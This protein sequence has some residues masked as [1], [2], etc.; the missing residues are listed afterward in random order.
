MSDKVKRIISFVLI[1]LISAV[2]LLSAG[3]KLSGSKEVVDGFTKAGLI[4]SLKLIAGLEILSTVLFLI[5]KTR[6]LGFF[7]LCSYLGGAMVT[8]MAG[9][10]PPIAAVFIA[11]LWIA[12]FLRDKT[13]F[14][15][16]KKA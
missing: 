5:P 13:M 2:M 10:E 16:V 12:M 6:N 1:F 4:G 8:Q 15:P 3:M 14:F 9:G 11:V 7:L